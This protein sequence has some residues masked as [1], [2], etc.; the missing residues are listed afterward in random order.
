MTVFSCASSTFTRP[1]LSV[2]LSFL[3]RGLDS[4]ISR[5]RT[6][7][8]TL[9]FGPT[10]CPAAERELLRHRR[11]PPDAERPVR[12][13]ESKKCAKPMRLW[14][15][16]LR[17]ECGADDRCPQ[18]GRRLH[19]SASTPALPSVRCGVRRSPILQASTTSWSR[20]AWSSS[21]KS[22]R[23]SVRRSRTSAEI[24]VRRVDNG[25]AELLW[26]L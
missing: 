15:A 11:T 13:S 7:T 6:S 4:P 3:N 18:R 16:A 12:P 23:L 10:S 21:A 22:E 25:C 9:F 1:S 8:N 14:P 5:A 19:P 20:C 24:F 17:R 2:G 26:G